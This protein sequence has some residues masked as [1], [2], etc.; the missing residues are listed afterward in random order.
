M[1]LLIQIW[2]MN[3][4]EE[5]PKIKH[6]MWVGAIPNDREWRYFELVQK[7]AK[8]YWRYFPGIEAV[9]LANSTALCMT[10]EESDI[11][12]LI[13]TKPGYLMLVRVLVTLMARWEW[14]YGRWGDEAGK[15]CLSFFVDSD[16]LDMSTIELEW[17]DPYLA[18]WTA[19]LVPVVTRPL[20]YR[21][22]KK[23]NSWIDK[24][25]FE[26]VY[27]QSVTLSSRSYP[28]WIERLL[29]MISDLLYSSYQ[30]IRSRYT[31][32]STPIKTPWGVIIEKGIQ[33]LHPNDK[34][35]EWRK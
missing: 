28:E 18:L 20:W 29:M 9:C 21:E 25:L 12:L 1:I 7:F 23:V 11:D 16:H 8:K 30:W 15:F 31:L 3:Y 14:L 4:I 19:R 10:H 5:I 22:W 17:G 24:D 32:N 33:K 27:N 34:R 2:S 26:D 13:V 6:R 35:M